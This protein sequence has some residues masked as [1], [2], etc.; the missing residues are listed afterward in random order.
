MIGVKRV[1]CDFKTMPE[2]PF[3]LLIGQSLDGCLHLSGKDDL[4]FAQTAWAEFGYIAIATSAFQDMF[5]GIP[6]L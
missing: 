2:E 3:E 1:I 5:T 6:S 4:L